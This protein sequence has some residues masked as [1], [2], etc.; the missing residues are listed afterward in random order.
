M[1]W[2]KKLPFVLDVDCAVN[3]ETF[4]IAGKGVVD[5]IGTYTASLRFSKLPR[6]FHP[7]LVTSYTVSICCIA[8]AAQRNGGMNFRT[9]LGRSALY[10]AIRQL[11]QQLAMK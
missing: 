9:L 7:V 8:E 11:A 6:G 4:T 3:G 1:R 10:E 2:T 5:P